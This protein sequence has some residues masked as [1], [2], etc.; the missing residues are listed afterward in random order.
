[1]T[2][3]PFGDRGKVLRFLPE[4]VFHCEIDE[5]DGWFG[6]DKLDLGLLGFW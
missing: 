3:H 1:M 2:G 5:V 6:G 4:V